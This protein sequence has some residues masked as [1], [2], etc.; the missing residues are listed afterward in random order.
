MHKLIGCL[1]NMMVKVILVCIY[2]LLN[3]RKIF[4]NILNLNIWLIIWYFCLLTKRGEV[5]SVWHDIVAHLLC[6]FFIFVILHLEILLD[7][8]PYFL[9][10][11]IYLKKK[12][13]NNKKSTPKYV[14][15]LNDLHLQR[16]KNFVNIY[17][18]DNCTFI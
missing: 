1:G 4:C 3:R 17:I 14:K 5:F 2:F 18:L 16:M 9:A 11:R 15:I 10:K 6:F 7:H 13:S 8:H 12:L